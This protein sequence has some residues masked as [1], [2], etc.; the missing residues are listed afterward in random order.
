MPCD[1][2]LTYCIVAYTHYL[3]HTHTLPLPSVTSV[4][5]LIAHG[6]FPASGGESAGRASMK[7]P[8]PA[9]AHIAR[10]RP[11]AS[12]VPA[13][14]PRPLAC[15]RLRT[16]GRL[17]LKLRPARACPWRLVSF[18]SLTTA[19]RLPYLA[20]FPHPTHHLPLV[21][22]TSPA[23]HHHSLW[24]FATILPFIVHWARRH[25]FRHPSLTNS[26]FV[27]A[28]RR[29]A[30]LTFYRRSLLVSSTTHYSTFALSAWLPDACARHGFHLIPPNHPDFFTAKPRSQLPSLRASITTTYDRRTR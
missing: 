14:S 2:W 15:V 16:D 24:C 26:F 6:I 11:G 12:Q 18:P 17:R 13:S 27:P 3:R 4:C 30:C 8:R 20:H 5:L 28:L 25:S 21:I 22:H 1:Q 19:C 7:S 23:L 9:A 10:A 29:V